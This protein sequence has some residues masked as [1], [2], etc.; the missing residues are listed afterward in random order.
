VGGNLNLLDGRNVDKYPQYCVAECSRIAAL[1][2]VG[3][4]VGSITGASEQ[5]SLMMR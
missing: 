5:R 2:S 4:D 1:K 3:E